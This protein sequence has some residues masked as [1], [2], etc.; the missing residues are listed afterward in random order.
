MG[1]Y[2]TMTCV[3]KGLRQNFYDITFTKNWVKDKRKMTVSAHGH[4]H[5]AR[6]FAEYE[7]EKLRA[8]LIVVLGHHPAFYL[9]ACCLAPYKH[10]D[11]VTA[12]SF[13]DEPLR[14]I[15]S[16]TWGADFLVPAD[17]EII[18]EAEILPGVREPQNPFGEIA[19]YYQPEIQ[20]PIAEV[21][22]VTMRNK[23]VMQGV[24]PG[25]TEH[26]HLGGVPKEG[27]VFSVVQRKFPG[28]KAVHLP[29]S[30]CCRFACFLSLK[31]EQENDPRRAGMMV[32]PEIENLKVLVVFDED[33]DIFN[34]REAWWAM[35]TR[36]HW[37]RDFEMISRVQAFRK[38][39]GHAVCIIDATRPDIPDFPQKNTIPSAAIQALKDRGLI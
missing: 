2:L 29:P 12:A 3:M 5:L 6:M 9:S 27:S 17:A 34:E 7:Q 4:H 37:E 19:G 11:Y 35:I 15:P 25:R 23:A 36:T 16:K 18:I 30:G 8:P 32:F 24:F 33:V 13:L 14:L 10:D 38:W 31:K 39:F 22:A 26:W 28:I 1:P 21:K 20:A